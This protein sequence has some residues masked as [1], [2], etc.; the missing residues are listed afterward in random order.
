MASPAQE[1]KAMPETKTSQQDQAIQ[2]LRANLDGMM[3]LFDKL[4]LQGSTSLECISVAADREL[5]V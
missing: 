4:Q 2:A 5:L 1:S 3:K